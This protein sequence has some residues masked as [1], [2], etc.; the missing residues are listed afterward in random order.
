MSSESPSDRMLTP[1]AVARRL[2]VSPGKILNLIRGGELAAID[3]AT[4]GSRRPRYRI[5]PDALERFIAARAVGS[6]PATQQRRR[7]PRVTGP[8]R[9]FV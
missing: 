5:D 3:V 6:P 7:R 9:E 8:V 2:G 4:R 1:P